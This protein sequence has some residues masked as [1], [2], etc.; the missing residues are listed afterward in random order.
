MKDILKILT[1]AGIAIV[2]A[3][4]VSF[5][6]YGLPPPPQASPATGFAEVLTSEVVGPG[7][8]VLRARS[9]GADVILRVLRACFRSLTPSH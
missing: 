4:G 2:V 7:G 9:Q 6:Q 1:A 5:A 8:A 3:G